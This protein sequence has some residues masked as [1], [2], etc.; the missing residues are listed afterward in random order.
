V[1]NKSVF[2]VIF[3]IG[4]NSPLFSQNGQPKPFYKCFNLEMNLGFGYYRSSDYVPFGTPNYEKNL[5]GVTV[6]G[7][8]DHS[9]F[10]TAFHF[11]YRNSRFKLGLGNEFFIYSTR[12]V[13][14]F[15]LNT[16]LNILSE[17][18]RPNTFFG[19]YV[20]YSFLEK[21]TNFFQIQYGFDYYYKQFH[22]GYRH[23]SVNYPHNTWFANKL[24][25][26]VIGYAFKIDRD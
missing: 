21:Y 11:N 12:M 8:R 1:L 20:S 10:N 16:A 4:I 19:P 25:Y 2:V 6:E 13:H 9:T 26:L 3:L 5:P 14:D 18:R 17:K 23:S 7:Y 22:I 15:N 24:D